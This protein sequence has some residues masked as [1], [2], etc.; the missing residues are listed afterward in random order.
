MDAV[1]GQGRGQDLARLG[2]LAARLVSAVAG[3][4]GDGQGVQAGLLATKLFGLLAGSVRWA[5]T[6]SAAQAG[7]VAV[8]DAAQHAQLALDA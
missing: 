6:S 1:H 5:S 8:L 7:A 2:V 4:D 3:A